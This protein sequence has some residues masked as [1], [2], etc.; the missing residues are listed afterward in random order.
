MVS[1]EKVNPEEEQKENE[2]LF[3]LLRINGFLITFVVQFLFMKMDGKRYIA[4]FLLICFSIFLGH[5]L[6]PHHH[7]AEIGATFMAGV[8]PADHEDFHDEQPSPLH[9]HAFNSLDFV[10]YSP[11][12]ILQPLRVISFWLVPDS[13]V[14][15]EQPPESGLILNISPKIPDKTI[16]YIGAISMRGPPVIA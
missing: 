3:D 9:C 12:K 4:P 13:S 16:K 14:E 5:S 6:V 15:L 11:T 10:N 7:Y 2:R 8:C 1:C